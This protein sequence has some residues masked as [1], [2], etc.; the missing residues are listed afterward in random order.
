MVTHLG[1]KTP[2]ETTRLTFKTG[3]PTGS[4]NRPTSPGIMNHLIEALFVDIANA[5][6]IKFL[7]QLFHKPGLLNAEWIVMTEPEI[8]TTG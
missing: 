7:P 5:F 8:G 3:L 4:L 6:V 2:I 1:R